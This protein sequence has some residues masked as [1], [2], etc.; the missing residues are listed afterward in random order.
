MMIY[1]KVLRPEYA[2][3]SQVGER[4]LRE[5]WQL[6]VDM[7]DLQ[8]TPEEDWDYFRSFVTRP[9]S[10]VLTFCSPDGRAQGFFTIA[11]MPVDHLGSKGLLLYSKYFYFREGYR[12]HYMTILAP[13]VLLPIGVRD[14]GLRSVH[15]VSTTFPQSFVSL[16]RSAGNVRTLADRETTP[17]QREALLGFVRS[18]YAAEFDETRGVIVGQNVVD[19]PSLPKSDEARALHS[20]Y[21]QLNPTWRQGH[22]LPIIFSVDGTLVRTVARRTIRRLRP[23]AH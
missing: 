4:R 16:S 7:L 21:E 17:W 2:E 20:R 13:W 5:L 10:A 6:R 14:Y 1:S 3:G 23:R 12:G 15:F 19:T 8:R 11:F 22:T 18:L 9:D